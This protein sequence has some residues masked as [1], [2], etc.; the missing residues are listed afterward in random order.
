LTLLGSYR[1]GH[2][3]EFGMRFRLISGNLVTPNVCNASQQTCDPFRVNALWN[4]AG[5][6]TP[7]PSA[8]PYSERLP[9]FPQLATRVDKRWV[10]KSWQMSAYLDVQNVYNNANAEGIDYNFNYTARRYVSGIPLLPNLGLRAD[11]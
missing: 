10:F 7:I 1:L 4:S 6:Y 5:V 9:L 8:A 2:G 11:F 3:W